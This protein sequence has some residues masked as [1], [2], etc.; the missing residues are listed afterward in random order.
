VHHPT[1]VLVL[2]L[3]VLLLLLLLLSGTQPTF[4]SFSVVMGPLLLLSS[5]MPLRLF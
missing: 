1:L 5:C 2:V 4:Q 3:L